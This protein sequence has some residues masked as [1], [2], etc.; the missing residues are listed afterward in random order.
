MREARNF[1]TKTEAKLWA[2]QREA[3]ILAGAEKGSGAVP[4]HTLREC[5][6]RYWREVC[7]QRRNA[8]WSWLRFALILREFPEL[9][10]KPLGDI[11]TA[12]LAA[13]RDAREILRNAG[14][15]RNIAPRR[16]QEQAV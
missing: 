16:P 15:H 10:D 8:R 5:I 1:A 4:R 14:F 6:E 12:D 7:A 9:A 2:T 3:E 13:W 11:T